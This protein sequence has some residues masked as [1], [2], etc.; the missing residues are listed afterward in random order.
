MYLVTYHMSATAKRN[1]DKMAAA[2][3]KAAA[4]GMKGWMAWAKKC[5]KQLVDMGT[6]LGNGVKLNQDGATP[7]KRNVAGYS[8][9]QA[10]S[11]AAAKK[12]M[13]NHPH[14]GW[15]AGCDIEVHESQALPGM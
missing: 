14:L 10:E 2:N 15:D 13:K 8:I 6:P 7:S 9:L 12:L 1:A 3:P 11:L 5:G 4:E